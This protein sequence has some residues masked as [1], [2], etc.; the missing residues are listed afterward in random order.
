MNRRKFLVMASVL[1]AGMAPWRNV[2]AQEAEVPPLT[3][4]GD[5]D[6]VWMNGD[7][8]ATFEIYAGGIVFEATDPGYYALRDPN[9]VK[10]F[11]AMAQKSRRDAG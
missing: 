3:E 9:P 7:P 1:P 10:A 5:M 2:M 4:G 11:T 6:A 8:L